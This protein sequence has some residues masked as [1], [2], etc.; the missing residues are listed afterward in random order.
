MTFAIGLFDGLHKLNSVNLSDPL[1]FHLK[2]IQK[3]NV[4][5]DC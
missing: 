1:T 3:A 5:V 4:A 2:S